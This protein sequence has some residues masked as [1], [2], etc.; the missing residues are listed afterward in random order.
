MEKRGK[1]RVKKKE[2]KKK[3]WVLRERKTKGVDKREKGV[4]QCMR[5]KNKRGNIVHKKYEAE[6]SQLI[7]LCYQTMD[8]DKSINFPFS[9]PLS[10][11][12]SLSLSPFHAKRPEGV[13]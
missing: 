6:L 9:I 3:K 7:P 11:S 5:K 12:L 4:L 1:T 8:K 2:E 10:H 13:Y